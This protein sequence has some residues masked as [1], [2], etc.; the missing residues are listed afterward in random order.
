MRCAV[1]LAAIALAGCSG[2]GGAAQPSAPTVYVALGD[3]MTYGYGTTDPATESFPAQFAAMRGTTAD[4]LG[5]D[6][7]NAFGMLQNEVGHVP[8]DATLVTVWIGVNDVD[9]MVAGEPVSEVAAQV[10]QAVADIRADAPNAVVVLLTPVD[11]SLLAPDSDAYKADPTT[12]AEAHAVT[13]AYDAALRTLGPRVCDIG[14]DP[15]YY[16]DP[17]HFYAVDHYHPSDAGAA[18][19]ATFV[20]ECVLS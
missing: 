19:I 3:S 15:A 14:E 6:G 11:V 10:A 20:Q 16:A 9:A 12:R 2:G 5:I 1:A 18:F 7:E 17:A 4:D 8:A 13:L